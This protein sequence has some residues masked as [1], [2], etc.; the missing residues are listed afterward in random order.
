MAVVVF[1]KI[2]FEFVRVFAKKNRFDYFMG[3]QKMW[4]LKKYFFTPISLWSN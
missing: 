4:S 3:D 1:R 2:F